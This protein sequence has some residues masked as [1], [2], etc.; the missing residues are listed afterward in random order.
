VPDGDG[1]LLDVAEDKAAELMKR[2]GF[3]RLR[4]AVEIAAAPSLAVAAAWGGPPR[5]SEGAIAYADPPLP[6]LGLRLLAP[7]ATDA[8]DLG[9]EPSSEADYQT[10]RIRLGVP[11]GGRDYAF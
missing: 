5:L 10:L 3:Y 8:A 2:V 1:F 7:K 11:E 9:C 4:A 6:E